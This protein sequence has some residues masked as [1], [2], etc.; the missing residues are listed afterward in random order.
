MYPKDL[1]EFTVEE[2]WSNLQKES[3]LLVGRP[4]DGKVALI[5]SVAKER[6]LQFLFVILNQL[7]PYS[8]SD[9][10]PLLKAQEQPTLILFDGLD[11]CAPEILKVVMSI[12]GDRVI[13]NTKLNTDVY[14]IATENIN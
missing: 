9:F 11:T 7:Y 3:C 8:P 6:G 2:I 4:G 14:L 12:M 1:K 5:Q 10:Q 13:N